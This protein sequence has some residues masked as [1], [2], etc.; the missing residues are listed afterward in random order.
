MEN[1]FHPNT[2]PFNH[3]F[4]L[5]NRKFHVFVTR[6]AGRDFAKILRDG[7][8]IWQDMIHPKSSDPPLGE[9]LCTRIRNGEFDLRAAIEE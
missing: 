6:M 4:H 9:R 5:G 8:I 7:K 1:F 2:G 3:S